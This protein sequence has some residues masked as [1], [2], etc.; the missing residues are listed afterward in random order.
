[1]WSDLESLTGRSVR[2]SIGK[3]YQ[4]ETMVEEGPMLF[5]VVASGKVLYGA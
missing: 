4:M 3:V 5:D 2:V 1:M